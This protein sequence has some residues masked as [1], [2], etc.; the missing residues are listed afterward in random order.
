MEAVRYKHTI[1]DYGLTFSCRSEQM[2]LGQ[3]LQLNIS[4]REAPGSISPIEHEHPTGAAVAADIDQ[5]INDRG[6]RI[7]M[8]LVEQSIQMDTRSRQELTD[9]MKRM[10]ALENPNSVQQIFLPEKRPVRL[11]P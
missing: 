6:V 3:V 10:T 8:E 2:V 1:T 7:D 9:A 11:A 4:S 5:E